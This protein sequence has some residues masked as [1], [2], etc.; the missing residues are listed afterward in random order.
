[1][2]GADDGLVAAALLHDVGH[3]LDLEANHGRAELP[4]DDLGHEAVGAQYLAAVFGPR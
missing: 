3:L 1:M 2:P 4:Q